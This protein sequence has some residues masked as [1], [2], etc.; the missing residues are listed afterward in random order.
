MVARRKWV[1]FGFKAIST[2]SLWRFSFCLLSTESGK[3][4]IH[5]RWRV[6]TEDENQ[7]HPF[8]KYCEGSFLV[9]FI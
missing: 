2:A 6:S 3:R 7:I 8:T 5:N 4:H 9:A 1:I